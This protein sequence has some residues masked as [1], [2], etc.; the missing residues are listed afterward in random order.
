MAD[1]SGPFVS[2]CRAAINMM[3]RKERASDVFVTDRRR[4][5][6]RAEL[7]QMAAEMQ[8]NT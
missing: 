2:L 6:P 1:T 7:Q 5:G 4:A 8:I 3:F